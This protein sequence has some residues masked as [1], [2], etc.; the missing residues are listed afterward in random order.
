M[1]M[2]DE[3]I[4]EGPPGSYHAPDGDVQAAVLEPGVQ[5]WQLLVYH[6]SQGAHDACK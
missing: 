1:H 2:C 6:H 3:V 4:S 5:P